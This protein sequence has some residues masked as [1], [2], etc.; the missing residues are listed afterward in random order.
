MAPSSRTAVLAI[1]HGEKKCGFAVADPLR[2]A[3]HALEP[4]RAPGDSP[5]FV[6]H[7]RGLLAERDVSTLVVGLPLN[8]DGSEG[9]R[10][11]RVR[12][13]ARELGRRFPELEV[14]LHDERLSTVEADELLQEAG[15]FGRHRKERRD[16]WSA[17]VI[18]RDWIAAGEPG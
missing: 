17:L 18:L 16:S 14:V 10:S 4:C 1:D 11:A 2:I 13:F 15:H 6:E 5:A 12:A 8:M 7:L 3:V 9:P